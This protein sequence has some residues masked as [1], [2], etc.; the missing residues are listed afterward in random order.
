MKALSIQPD[1]TEPTNLCEI[2]GEPV[3]IKDP[4][5]VVFMDETI[6][7][8]DYATPEK[9]RYVKEDYRSPLA[10]MRIKE[11]FPHPKKIDDDKSVPWFEKLK[12][13]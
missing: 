1:P 10:I 9:V 2:F 4:G 12:S 8:E 3:K 7:D 6:L 11:A 13:I 5:Q